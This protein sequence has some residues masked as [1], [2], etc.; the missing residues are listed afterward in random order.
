M[1]FAAC[2]LGPF[3]SAA[4]RPSRWA[5]EGLVCSWGGG[6]GEAA[7]F[8]PLPLMSLLRHQAEFVPAAGWQEQLLCL[9][10]AGVSP[11]SL[12]VIL[13][14]CLLLKATSRRGCQRH[15]M[16]SGPAQ[17]KQRLEGCGWV[18]CRQA[19]ASQFCHFCSPGKGIEL[20]Q[21][22]SSQGS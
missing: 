10:H 7:G 22:A 9:G 17:C 6:G 5:G 15:Q 11:T 1:P 12:A 21:A 2:I 14:T 8:A 4:C 18:C 3:D 13:Q 20:R 16:F 19:V